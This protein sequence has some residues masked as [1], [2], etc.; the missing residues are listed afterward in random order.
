MEG[1]LTRETKAHFGARVVDVQLIP[2]QGGFHTSPRS[3]G[4]A[5]TT[6]I[7]CLTVSTSGNRLFHSH[8]SIAWQL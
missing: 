2:V 8:A 3:G 5:L 1:T 4:Q 6:C 7:Y